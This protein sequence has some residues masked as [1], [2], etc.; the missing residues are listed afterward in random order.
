MEKE[1]NICVVCGGYYKFRMSFIRQ[2][3][4][5]SPQLIKIDSHPRCRSLK[6]IIE[7]KKI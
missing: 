4:N 5:Q 2:F 6:I 3:E 7:K 1:N